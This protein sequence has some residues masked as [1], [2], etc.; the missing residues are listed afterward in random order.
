MVFSVKDSVLQLAKTLIVV[1]M[2]HT[3]RKTV[4]IA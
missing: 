1:M 4:F 3:N 2:T